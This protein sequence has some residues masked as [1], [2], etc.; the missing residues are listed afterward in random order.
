MGMFINKDN[1]TLTDNSLNCH[2]RVHQIGKHLWI[3]GLGGCCPA[4]KLLKKTGDKESVWIGFPYETD[5][6]SKF[7]IEEL[8]NLIK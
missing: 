4:V 1:H 8:E 2:K 5:D 3:A 7:D 6:D